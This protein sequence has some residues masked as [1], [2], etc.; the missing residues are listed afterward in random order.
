LEVTREEIEE[1]IERLDARAA[2]LLIVNKVKTSTH[3][4]CSDAAAALR[5]LLQ[6]QTWRPIEEAPKDGT[7]I[8][9]SYAGIVRI[10]FWDTARGGIWSIWPGRERASPS[11]WMPLP[12]SSFEERESATPSDQQNEGEA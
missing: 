2:D 6:A 4:L 3:N 11:R 9:A 5:H 10:V 7:E 12:P 1:L 8:L